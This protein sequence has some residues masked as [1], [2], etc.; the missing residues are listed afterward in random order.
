V[1]VSDGQALAEQRDSSHIMGISKE[2]W[3]AAQESSV[4]GAQTDRRSDASR[5]LPGGA[6]RR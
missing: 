5:I 2:D 3:S 1:L 6:G 4:P